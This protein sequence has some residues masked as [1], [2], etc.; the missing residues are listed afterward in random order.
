MMERNRT[1]NGLTLDH[2]LSARARFAQP[3]QKQALIEI[4]AS[5]SDVISLGRGDPDL[6]TPEVIVQAGVQALKEGATGYTKWAGLP[7]LRLAI[8][9]RYS[10]ERNV[11]T[12]ADEVLVTVG[13]QE[14]VLLSM[15]SFIEEGD[16][17]IVFEPRYTAYDIAIQIAGGRII[18]VPTFEQDSFLPQPEAIEGV[19]T[20]RTKAILLVSPDNPTGSVIPL[21]TLQEIADV[22]RR[23]DL[24]VISDELYSDLV[25]DE[26]GAPSIASL[27]G[28]KQRTVIING[29]SKTFCMTGW[30]VGYLIATPETAPV[31]CEMKSAMT[32]CAPNVSQHAALAAL[33]SGKC[34]IEKIIQ[35]Y[36]QR[37]RLVMKCLNDLK[38][39][40][41]QPKGAFYVFA[42]IQP[43]CRSATSLAFAKELLLQKR[44]LLFPGTIFGQSG[45]GYVRISLL[46]SLDR[47]EEAFRR[48]GE[49]IGEQAAQDV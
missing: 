28:M 11:P 46:E 8:A 32:I 20:K 29:F 43:V 1:E 36:D 33:Q 19:I 37:R 17:V 12:H 45:E 2:A 22:A 16:E 9:E 21:D 39:S 15:L 38:L 14:A 31:M 40:F 4:A 30:R 47:L 26:E 35:I 6:R 24:L 23:N 44:V 34:E 48:I 5:L 42:N 10:T 18:S 27:P 41:N 25:Y 13:A 49:F 3:G 7:E